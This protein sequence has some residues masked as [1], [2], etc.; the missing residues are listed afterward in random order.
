MGERSLAEVWPT[1]ADG[2]RFRELGPEGS[3]F[4]PV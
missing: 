1:D 3:P 4:L 2:K